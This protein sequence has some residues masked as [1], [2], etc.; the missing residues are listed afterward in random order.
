MLIVILPFSS[1]KQATLVASPEIIK[2][3]GSV[4]I[5]GPAVV[6]QSPLSIRI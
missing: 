6:W 4:I 5:I 2:G 1:P 3:I